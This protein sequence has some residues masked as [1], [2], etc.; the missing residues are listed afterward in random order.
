MSYYDKY[1]FFID[2]SVNIVARDMENVIKDIEVLLFKQVETDIA[3]IKLR[4][5]GIMQ[6]N[7][8]PIENYTI[9]DIKRNNEAVAEIGEGKAYPNLVV[10]DHF[11]NADADLRA[12]A[13]SEESNKY[14][15]ADAFVVKLMAVKLIGNIYISFNK[16]RRPTRLF[17]NVEDA[18]KWLKSFL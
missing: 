6:F 2:T 14:T 5:D 18:E 8:K 10:V 13:A 7:L 12:Y 15:V 9:D 16:P 11:L 3:V 4:E 1:L 17:N